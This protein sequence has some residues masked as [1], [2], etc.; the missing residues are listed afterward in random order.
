MTLIHI[1]HDCPKCG[2]RVVLLVFAS[3]LHGVEKGEWVLC[4]HCEHEYAI[5]IQLEFLEIKEVKDGK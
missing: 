1:T 4:T 2:E 3:E 5:A